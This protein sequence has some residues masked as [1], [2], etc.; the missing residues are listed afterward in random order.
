MT[1]SDKKHWVFSSSG[2][3]RLYLENIAR[4]LALPEG[5][6]LLFRYEEDIVSPAFIV[7][8]NEAQGVSAVGDLVY[9]SYLSNNTPGQPIKV[10]PVREGEI[11]EVI[12]R[13][14]SYFIRIKL[15]R[16]PNWKDQDL[17]QLVAQ[18][19]LEEL[20]AKGPDTPMGGGFWAAQI[21]PFEDTVFVPYKPHGSAHLEAFDRAVTAISGEKD[22]ND[23]SWMFANIVGLNTYPDGTALGASDSLTAGKSY[24]LVIYH[25]VDRSKREGA[26]RPFKMSLAIE[27]DQASFLSASEHQI[28]AEYDEVRFPFRL[29]EDFPDDRLSVAINMSGRT[30]DDV[31]SSVLNAKVEF[32]VKRSIRPRLIQTVAVAIGIAISQIGAFVRS[33]DFDLLTLA[34]I[35]AGAGAAGWFASRKIR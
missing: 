19:A 12:K 28:L 5:A 26:F 15:L 25:F 1:Q 9:L 10:M 27:S 6:S 20:P 32:P 24:E 2:A 13:G 23:G 30:N 29:S 34:L 7:R 31:E 35:V 18:N 14:S 22:F 33:D 11:L 4:A 17:S 3:R 16:Y 21:T 8:Y